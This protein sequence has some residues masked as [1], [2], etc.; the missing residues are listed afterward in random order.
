MSELQARSAGPSNTGL[1]RKQQR[2]A[3]SGEKNGQASSESQEYVH[4]VLEWHV[5]TVP[6]LCRD[7]Q[8]QRQSRVL[9]GVITAACLLWGKMNEA[10]LS[11]LIL[12]FITATSRPSLS[13]LIYVS[14]CSLNSPYHRLPHR[15]V[16]G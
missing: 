11:V 1:W 5:S 9:Q 8:G 3:S 2:S 6:K 7:F 15:N 10:E 4:M 14:R 13:A 16:P 12:G